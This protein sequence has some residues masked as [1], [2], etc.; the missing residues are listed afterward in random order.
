MNAERERLARPVWALADEVGNTKLAY[1][2]ALTPEERA[3]FDVVTQ[4]LL[5]LG[6]QINRGE[7]TDAA[8]V[9]PEGE[10]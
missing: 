8:P 6:T 1:R 10:G 4:R 3:A 5:H 7:V 2:Q 9:P